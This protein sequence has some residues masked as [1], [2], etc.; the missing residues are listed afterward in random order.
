MWSNTLEC[1][2]EFPGVLLKCRFSMFEV[3][4]ES[5]FLTISLIQTARQKQSQSRSSF[6][7]QPLYGVLYMSSFPLT[8]Q[9]GTYLLSVPSYVFS[10]PENI[11]NASRKCL[12]A[13]FCRYKWFF[14]SC[15][16]IDPCL[17]FIPHQKAVESCLPSPFSARQQSASPYSFLPSWNQLVYHHH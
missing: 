2:Y 15:F 14:V 4:L 3:G 16:L 7:C 10:L 9:K 12:P 11:L 17:S 8:S 1:A 13:C 5:A 6:D